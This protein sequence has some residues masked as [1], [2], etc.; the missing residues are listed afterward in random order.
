MLEGHPVTVADTDPSR[1]NLVR[2]DRV[3]GMPPVAPVDHTLR[4][5]NKSGIVVRLRGPGAE[6][7]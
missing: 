4:Q 6:R 5:C 3:F 7:V 2:A 1:G